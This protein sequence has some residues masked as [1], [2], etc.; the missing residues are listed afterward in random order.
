MI[1]ETLYHAAMEASME[2]AKKD[3]AYQSFKGSPL[4]MGKF[5]MDLWNEKPYTD[6]Y[7]WETLR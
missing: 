3:G 5:Q 6:R 1:F 2:L 7:D 4:S